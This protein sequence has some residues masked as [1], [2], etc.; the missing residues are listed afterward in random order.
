AKAGLFLEVLKRLRPAAEE[1]GRLVAQ[2]LEAEGI[3]PGATIL[4][5]GC[6]DGRLGLALAARGYRVVGIDVS[7]LLI[8]E[9]RRRAREQGV[10]AEFVAGDARR[11]DEVLGGRRFDAI[12]FY[13]GSVIGYYS[14]SADED[15]LRR[16][17]SVASPGARLLILRHPNKLGLQLMASIHGYRGFYDVLDLEDLVVVQR[18]VLEPGS[19][20]MD[21]AW[22]V[23]R[24][25]GQDL[26]HLGELRSCM[27]LYTPDEL[28]LLAGRAGWRL[29][30]V[31]PR[32]SDPGSATALGA[33]PT[34]NLVFEA[35][36]D[37][38]GMRGE[39]VQ[40]RR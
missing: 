18:Y 5:V 2:L 15:V 26:E 22:H 29:R 12:I 20:Y 7:S 35:S 16:C 39:E 1:E 40:D 32:L 14:D 10:E 17:R 13:W 9:A 30:R 34:M 28:A 33:S 31:F 24:R 21:S 4:D 19:S 38:V 27:R 11:V 23:Y 37:G 25:R 8:E 3:G 36:V 6:G